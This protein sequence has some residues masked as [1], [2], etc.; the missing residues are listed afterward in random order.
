MALTVRA[1]KPEDAAALCRLN[2]AF[3]E[4]DMP[5]EAAAASLRNSA[6][7]VFLAEMDGMAAGFCCAQVHH[8]FC[9]PAPVAEVT[10]LYV[11]KAYRRM[12]CAFAML[13]FS[14][15]YLKETY[16]VEECHLLTGRANDA[17]RALYESCGYQSS[18]E[19]YLYKK[20]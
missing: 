6:E 16:G 1:A 4:V 9:Y 3:N 18:D 20:L 17:A 12:G 10:E 19:Q 5:E 11:D 14:E 2:A 15:T 7:C 13:R 8:S